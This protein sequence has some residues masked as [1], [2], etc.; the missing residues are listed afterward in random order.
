MRVYTCVSEKKRERKREGGKG[1]RDEPECFRE[2]RRGGGL[3]AGTGTL[4]CVRARLLKT[5]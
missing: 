4:G 1:V 3:A 5:H 2:E